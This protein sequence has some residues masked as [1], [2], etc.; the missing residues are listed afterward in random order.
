MLRK[1]RIAV[2][3]LMV[4]ILV[5]GLF[6]TTGL[7]APRKVTLWSFAA[8]NIEE[9]KAREADI[10]AKFK[11]DLDIVTVAEQAFV[12]KLQ[13]V[14]MDGKN[15]PDLVEWRIESNQILNADPKK[16][17]CLPLDKWTSKSP[18]FKNVVPGRVAWTTYGGHVYGLP[19]DVHPVVLVYNDTLWKSVG[20]D[21]ATVE[22]WDDFFVQ[23]QKLTA[24]KKD[25][26][27]VHYAL[28]SSNSGL[29]DTMWMI[30]QQT[31]SQ[32]L[33]KE[34]KPT[35]EDPAFKS[36]VE[37]WIKWYNTGVFTT[38]DWGAFGM[39]LK[40]GTLASY[41][42]PDWWISQVFDAANEGK[43]QFRVR[44][45]PYYKKGG[46]R[47]SSWGGTFLGMIK[48]VKN[49]DQLYKIMEYMQYDETGFLKY[50]WPITQMLPPFSNVWNSPTFNQPDPHF[51]GQ[52]LGALQV[53]CAKEMPSVNSGDIFWNAVSEFGNVYPDMVSG[54][55][56]VDAGLKK[57]QEKALT[58]K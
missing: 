41:T 26:K 46:P 52:K 27:P 18:V 49:P 1:G 55:I 29:A 40:N 12:Q 19:H 22:T 37:Q 44:A 33:S 25:G 36:F 53:Q 54:K 10:E 7:A 13:A 14:M 24:E 21:I 8:N 48:T 58:L 57:V 50:R 34:G 56:S 47:T 4:V 30:W 39:A 23:A 3:L 51:G 32:I 6:A 43:Y 5:I 42:S 20:V 35:F 16:S 11:I 28:P 31:G 9:W 2:A 17:F 15:V 38:W 45:L